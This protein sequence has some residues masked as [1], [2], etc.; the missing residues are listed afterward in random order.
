MSTLRRKIL[1][2]LKRI[3]KVSMDSELRK[4]QIEKEVISKIAKDMKIELNIVDDIVAKFLL[5]KDKDYNA[6]YSEAEFI[7]VN[8]NILKSK[9][10]FSQYFGVFISGLLF[11]AFI[12]FMIIILYN[13]PSE[14]IIDNNSFVYKDKDSYT[15]DTT[16]MTEEQEKRYDNLSPEGQS[17]VDERMKQYDDY[18][19]KSSDC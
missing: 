10:S 4:K 1:N 6:N 17:Y 5:E 12:L 3:Y 11:S 19:S 7:S 14:I 9:I 15:K 18:C 8:E 2:R 13:K 16:I